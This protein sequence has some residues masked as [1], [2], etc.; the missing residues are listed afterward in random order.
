MPYTGDSCDPIPF[1]EALWPVPLTPAGPLVCRMCTCTCPLRPSPAAALLLLLVAPCR[2]QLPR[3]ETAKAGFAL[4]L[5]LFPSCLE[6]RKSD[7]SS[8]MVAPSAMVFVLRHDQGDLHWKVQ[9][10]EGKMHHSYGY[11]PAQPVPRSSLCVLQALHHEQVPQSLSAFSWGR[12]L[13]KCTMRTKSTGTAVLCE[14]G[15]GGSVGHGGRFC[16]VKKCAGREAAGAE[17]HGSDGV[18]LVKGVRAAAPHVGSGGRPQYSSCV[19]FA[20]KTYL[21]QKAGV[22]G[23]LRNGTTRLPGSTYGRRRETLR[24]LIICK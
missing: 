21:M 19:L 5:T 9:C 24:E 2:A 17:L 22:L 1:S 13:L 18:A 6:M 15:N 11:F 14:M 20:W 10:R 16:T 8:S 3:W 4:P 7:S 23:L 12:P